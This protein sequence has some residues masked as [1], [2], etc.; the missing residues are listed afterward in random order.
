MMSQEDLQVCGDLIDAILFYPKDG[1]AILPVTSK[2]GS[3]EKMVAK[4]WMNIFQPRDNMGT[5]FFRLSSLSAI[6]RLV[7]GY[8]RLIELDH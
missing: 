3:P 8:D 6:Q 7:S 1:T 2:P 4:T 5:V